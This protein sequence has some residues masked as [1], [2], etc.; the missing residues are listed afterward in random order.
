MKNKK[1]PI[2]ITRDEHNPVS[3]AKRVE[4][5][6]TEMNIELNHNDGD[7]V[8]SH[9]AKLTASALGVDSNDDGSVII[10]ALDCSS[11]RSLDVSINGTGAIE[12]MISPVDSGD[13]FYPTTNSNP[14]L[15]ARRIM[16]KSVDVIGDVHIVGRS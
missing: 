9:P 3:K 2:H 11:I 5:V 13:F 16:I 10:P 6:A 8:T 1:D 4:I 15:V 12:V 7:S 14:N